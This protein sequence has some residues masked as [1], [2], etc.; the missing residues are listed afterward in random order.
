M[1]QFYFENKLNQKIID[2]LG[3]AKRF[4]KIAVFQIHSEK[5]FQLLIQKAKSGVEV[6]IITLPVDS[7][8]ENEREMVRQY[9]GALEKAGAIVSFCKWN[10]G[11]PER[12][13]TAV[14]RWYSFH[15]KFI[16]TDELAIGLS[17]NLMNGEE[18]DTMIVY[19]NEKEMISLFKSKFEFLRN[20]FVVK[21]GNT[22]GTIK[23]EILS[24]K[25]TDPAVSDVFVAPRTIT[26]TEIKNFWIKEYPPTLCPEEVDI[27]DGLYILPF[28]C[29]PRD[30]LSKIILDAK[31]FVYLS[32]ES[33]TDP[34]FPYLLEKAR[35][36]GKELKILTG[37]QSMDYTDRLKLMIKELI[38]TDIQ[39][40][41]TTESIHAK[42]IIT[43]KLVGVCSINLNRINLGFKVGKY[44]RSNTETISICTD[45]AVIMDAKKIFDKMFGDDTKT[46]SLLSNLSEKSC[47]DLGQLITK[48]FNF[49]S[50]GTAKELLAKIQIEGEIGNVSG[51]YNLIKL[52][53]KNAQER[54]KNKIDKEDVEQ[55]LRIISQKHK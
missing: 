7:V 17:A 11:D 44:W 4:I 36:S 31:K 22:E 54:G 24:F 14:G 23:L 53:I 55:A 50:S 18:Y 10:I 13:T 51:V 6:E 39:M 49:R 43:D 19:K 3:S 40:R 16:V 37:A 25:S 46:K 32:T 34:S 2:C 33:F 15:G 47:G 41:T 45:P 26:D 27:K 28:D 42:L 29:R 52:A 1:K 21:N 30:F 5:V 48:T 20:K 8:D 35:L 12:T 9:F 38:A